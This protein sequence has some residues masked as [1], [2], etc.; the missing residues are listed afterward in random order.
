VHNLFLQDLA[1][2]NIL[3]GENLVCKVADFGLSREIDLDT[4]DGAYTT[5]VSIMK[6]KFKQWWS[7]MLPISAK[8]KKVKTVMC[9]QCYQYQQNKRK[10]NSDVSTMLPIST[11]QKEVKT[12]MCQ[13]CYQYQQNKRNLKQ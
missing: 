8:Q 10:L 13:Q 3:I 2:R 5:K 4:T 1:A 12:V 11:K 9:Q 7:T 6:R